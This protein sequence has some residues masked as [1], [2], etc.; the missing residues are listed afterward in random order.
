MKE[1]S[2]WGAVRMFSLPRALSSTGHK[3]VSQGCYSEP[4]PTFPGSSLVTQDNLFLQ[5]CDPRQ[6]SNICC[7]IYFLNTFIPTVLN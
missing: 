6:Q 1:E 5:W 2:S 7:W 3:A 4:F